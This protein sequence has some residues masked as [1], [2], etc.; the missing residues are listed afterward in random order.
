MTTT[1]RVDAAG[2]RAGDIDGI[3][4]AGKLAG[5]SP[6]ELAET[7]GTPFYVYDLDLI[8][9]RVDA[10]RAVL[11]RGFRV[12]FAV[13]A[14]PALAIVAHLRRCGVGADV[15]SGG[16]LETVLRA[17]FDPAIVSMTGPGKRDEE[18]TAA[19]AAGIGFIT[20]E[21]PGELRRL[22]A[23]AAAAGRRQPILL[24]LAVAEDARLE[25]V[26]IIG[27]VEGKFGMPLHTLIET[28][29][30]AS[31]SKHVELLGVHAFGASNLRDAEQL[32]GHVSELVEIGRRVA[33]AAGTQ[34]RVVDAGGGLGIPYAEGERRLDLQRLGRRLSELRVRW[35][36]DE[37]L[38]DMELVL[39]PGRF[40]VGPAGAYVA[41][42]VD[43]KGPDSAPVAILDGGINHVLRPALLQSEQRLAV[44]SKDAVRALVHAT[45]AGPLCT[46]LDVFTAGAM[47]PRPRV[48]D[49]VAVL[50][51]GA[52]GFTESMPFFL[53][54]PTAAEVA[55]RA[56]RASLI[57]PRITPV[58][59]L[60][61]QLN[62]DW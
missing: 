57:R 36:A 46:G 4:D 1:S 38:H 27:G 59:L 42:V 17:G 31:R 29:R 37:A 14:N 47:L 11:P 61:R 30:A 5:L 26:R 58:E 15:A 53:S 40:L 54:H 2:T 16:E 52:Y 12:A 19:V 23:I 50:D 56:G 51:A 45:V 25:T 48:G 22:E 55:V 49:L 13:K 44:L 9:R 43:V 28:A 60:D 8:G 33:S 24:R 35:D 7:F 21:S 39:E 6:A 34:L 41:R 20:V 32:A 3:L 18:L 10:L 62:P